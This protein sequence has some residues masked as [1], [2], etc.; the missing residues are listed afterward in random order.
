MVVVNNNGVEYDVEKAIKNWTE[1]KIGWISREEY[2]RVVGLL[3]TANLRI[4]E[5]E[6]LLTTANSRIAEL[7]AQ[8]ASLQAQ[9]DTAEGDL[10]FVYWLFSPVRPTWANLSYSCSWYWD[11]W[12]DRVNLMVW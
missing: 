3:E 8:V 7:E 5:L 1:Y 12:N 11:N 4:I 9:L 2:N 10:D 6:W